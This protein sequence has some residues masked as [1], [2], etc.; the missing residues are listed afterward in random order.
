MEGRGDLL[1]KLLAQ[2]NAPLVVRID[3]PDR[4]LDKGNVLVQGDKGAQRVRGE[5]DAKD[6]RC[7]T[8]AL[9]AAGGNHPLGSALGAY[10]VSG[11]AKG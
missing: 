2:L 9:E 6:G 3:S 11:L 1:G 4:T 8:V 10:L 7:G 5:V